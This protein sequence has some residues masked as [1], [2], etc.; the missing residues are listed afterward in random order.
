MKTLSDSV[1]ICAPRE[2][3]F[4]YVT[5]P[6]KMA[7]WLPSMMET[8]NV[9]GSGEGSQY[10]W[11][12]KMVGNLFHGQTVVVEHVPHERS[13]YKSIGAIHSDWTVR[14]EARDGRTRVAMDIEYEVPLPV[15]G[16]L[17]ERMLEKRHARSLSVALTNL[18][19]MLEASPE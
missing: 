16:K 17:A 13:E 10:E 2:A 6:S 8:R 3:V 5:E 12:Y 19:E 11:T 1:V 7:E 14:F 4:E 9:V 15:L 18:K